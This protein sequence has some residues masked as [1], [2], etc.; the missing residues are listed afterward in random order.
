MRN[1]SKGCFSA[2]LIAIAVCSISSTWSLGQVR[3]ESPVK[4]QTTEDCYAF[5]KE[6]KSYSDAVLAKS[7]QCNEMRSKRNEF[8]SFRPSCGGSVN[9]TSYKGCEKESDASWCAWD[10]FSTKYV[11]CMKNVHYMS[12]DRKKLEDDLA[13][14]KAHQE[15]MKIE[16][17]RES[18]RKE[19]VVPR[20]AGECDIL[21][22]S[23]SGFEEISSSPK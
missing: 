4:P 1:F 7:H 3:P 23:G 22:G 6:Q 19:T 13:L 14:N 11:E 17:L 10:G 21:K 16:A 5:Q 20:P 15:A 2:A 8:S 18:C 9:I 12:K